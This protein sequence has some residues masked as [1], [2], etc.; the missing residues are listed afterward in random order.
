MREKIYNLK[1]FEYKVR[2]MQFGKGENME[3]EEILG[4]SKVLI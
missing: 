4:L 3:V 2:N 1:M